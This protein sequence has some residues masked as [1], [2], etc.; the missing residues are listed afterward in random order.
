MLAHG[1]PDGLE[2]ADVAPRLIKRL[3]TDE[4]DRGHEWRRAAVHDRRFR[5]IE[6]DD[7]VVDAEPAQRRHDVL[8]RGD[9]GP[10]CVA[11][12]GSELG[13][14]DRTGIGADLA[15]PPALDAADE[16]DAG[17]G[18]G[19][20]CRERNGKPGMDADPRNG[21]SAAKRGLLARFHASSAPSPHRL[22]RDERARSAIP[23]GLPIAVD[24][25]EFY[26]ADRC[27]PRS[28]DA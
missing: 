6:L 18:I 12:H 19:R 7:G 25:R 13:R 22:A 26:D 1:D 24:G 3:E 14:G 23:D 9:A 28:P 27:R 11:Q 21:G 16:H 20:M 15:L 17:V 5:T 4:I 2:H 8:D 10:G